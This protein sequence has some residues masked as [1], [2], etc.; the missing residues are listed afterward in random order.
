M[1]RVRLEGLRLSGFKSFPDSVELSFPSEVS[2]IIGPNGCGKSNLVDAIV[3]VLGEQSPTLLRL[4]QMGEVVFSGAAGRPAAGAAE[5]TLLLSSDDGHWKET[6]GRLEIQRRV[7]RSGPSEYRL[8][9]RSARLKDVVDELL[10]VG[11]GTR[12]YSIIEQGRVGQV[13][14]ARPTDRRILIEEAAGVTRYKKRKHEAQLKL[15]HTRQ[16]LARLEDI[17][18]EVDRNLRQ[19]RRQARQAE[20]H[21]RLREELEGTLRRLL[22]HHARRVDRERRELIRQRGRAENETAAAAATLAGGEADL[23][24]GRSA[25][26]ARRGELEKVRAE[27]T[28]M[29]GARERREAFVERSS[30][31]ID[32]LRDSLERAHTDAAAFSSSRAEIAQ[33]LTTA[34]ARVHTLEEAQRE[35]EGKVAE[36]TAAEG[37]ARQRLRAAERSTEE[38]RQDLLRTISTLTSTRNQLSET[39]RA[40]DRLGYALTQLEQERVGLATRLEDIGERAESAAVAGREALAAADELGQRRQALAGQRAELVERGAACRSEEEELG[41]S[42]WELRHRLTGVERELARHGAAA[43]HLLSALPRDAMAGQVSD[44]VR[45]SPGLAPLL[46]RVW[47]EWLE[48]PVV[49]VEGLTAD[50]LTAVAE[51]EGRVRLV[52]AT[53]A[54]TRDWPPPLEGAESL[55]DEAGIASEDRP[56]LLLTLPAVYRCDRQEDARA[57]AEAHPD[58][59]VVAPDEVLWRGR[60]MEPPTAGTRLRGA[61]SLRDERAELRRGIE[62]AEAE[63]TGVTGRRRE[64]LA[65][66][67]GVENALRAV[68]AELVGAEQERART[69]AVEQ[70]LLDERARLERELKA[71]DE[72]AAR[73]RAQKGDMQRR[74][75]KLADEVKAIDTRSHELE[76]A[77][78]TASEGLQAGRG[79]TAE[80]LRRLDRWRAEL[81]LAGERVTTARTEADRLGGEAEELDRRITKLAS[82]EEQLAGELARTEQEV[83]QS[84]A[85][86]VEEHGLLAAARE[87]ERKLAEG[88]QE[89]SAAVARAEGEVR[90]ARE[91]HEQARERLHALTLDEARLD[92]EWQRLRETAAAELHTPVEALATAAGEEETEEIDPEAEQAHVEELRAKIEKL[93]PVNLLAL[94]EVGELEE[95]SRFLGEQRTDLVSALRKLDETVREIDVVCTERFVATVEQVNSVFH[96]TF[97]TLFAGGSAC[98]ELVDPDDP[99]ESGIDIIAQPPGKKTQSVQLLSGGEKALTALSLLIS[100]FRIRPSPFCVLDEVDAP[101][102]DANVERLADLIETMTEHTQFVLITHNRRTMATADVLYGVTMEEPGVSK[103]V[104]VRLED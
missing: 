26:E 92:A 4:Q 72:E 5:V 103:V 104:S 47:R 67:E 76:R 7:F 56:W 94:E 31:L 75:A 34:A 15:E 12:D 69:S 83:V 8:N 63:L 50:Q 29:L 51:E 3:W 35:V 93:G 2:A 64:A 71:V 23:E 96:E 20:R 6:G 38:R 87:R 101:L 17:V 95:R 42:L 49:R 33:R 90:S 85:R 77:L 81:R 60:T 91:A 40:L 68:E 24:D 14:S 88:L 98:L 62:H 25:L 57:L 74:R 28:E 97:T 18:G 82:D 45:P 37:D 39:E 21:R 79:E 100:L 55:L 102:D 73:S 11:L 89:R 41:R 44:Y 99:L 19:L 70:S 80:A 9:G 65:A 22:A 58:V 46:D 66:L 36:A 52:V 1:T 43:E 10:G 13:L 59:I 27:I 54:P 53:P 78:E 30:D 48:L 16:N 86:L 61:L 32:S 84:R